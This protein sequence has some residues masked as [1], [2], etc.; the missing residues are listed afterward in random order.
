[1]EVD[2]GVDGVGA[3]DGVAC[4]L[5]E[6]V[7]GEGVF[8]VELDEDG[9]L[10]SNGVDELALGGGSSIG[11]GF[12]E[13]G[14]GGGKGDVAD[15]FNGDEAGGVLWELGKTSNEG[16]G[17]EGEGWG[18]VGLV[19]VGIAGKLDG[20]V[21]GGVVGDVDGGS[22]GEGWV[23]VDMVFEVGGGELVSDDCDVYGSGEGAVVGA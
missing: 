9:A 11:D 21:L 2:G 6:S 3:C 8:A 22:C 12:G 13:G 19:G 15:V 10:S 4:T 17:E 14:V 16:C 18:E 5:D 1:M 23:E 7:V 20:D